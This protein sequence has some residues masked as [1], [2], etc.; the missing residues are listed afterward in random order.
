[1]KSTRQRI[2]D[3]VENRRVATTAELSQA[4][5][6]TKANVRHHV[7]NLL[8][9]GLL[10]VS[11]ER[12]QKGR[13]RPSRLLSLADRTLGDNLDRLSS[14][15]LRE[16]LEDLPEAEYQ[17]LIT[18]LAEALAKSINQQSDEGATYPSFNLARRLVTA[19]QTLN[20]LNYQARWEA[21]AEAPRVLFGHCPYA[22]IIDE[23]PEL[24]H[25]DAS[26]LEHFL[27]NPAEQTEKLARDPRG[28]TYCEFTI[29]RSVEKG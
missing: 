11:G 14:A 5:H 25:M 7:T 1:M 20:R 18:R 9:Q 15:L 26:L 24:C 13:G 22:K 28:A 16:F 2:L 17:A 19:V 21:H 23:H 10:E 4:L 3:Y 27:H 8:E 12:P 29:K 6:V